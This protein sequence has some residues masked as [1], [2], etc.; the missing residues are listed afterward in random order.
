MSEAERVA[1]ARAAPSDEAS[2]TLSWWAAVLVL[3]AVEMVF[4]TMVFARVYLAG[5]GE[6]APALGLP[7]LSTV[8][9]VASAVPVLLVG[10]RVAG[11][12]RGLGPGV[13]FAVAGALGVVHLALQAA[14]YSAMGLDHRTVDDATFL[15]LVGFH[16][17]F[18]LV[19]L[20]IM[21]G[22]GLLHVRDQRPER[23]RA[24][25]RAGVLVWQVMVAS[26]LI[27]FA[28]LY[29]VPRVA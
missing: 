22:V 19:A 29:V 17:V 13:G 25:V 20:G 27:P 16:H 8:C 23:R 5:A 21:V 9:L 1:V 18:L 11:R 4:L 26:W 6:R 15:L 2:G 10:R 3:I 12:A 7:V 14:D 28:L 24:S